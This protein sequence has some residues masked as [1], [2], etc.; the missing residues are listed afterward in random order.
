MRGDII[1]IR[2]KA[3]DVG[4]WKP[5]DMRE[6]V[7]N[8]FKEKED[9][10]THRTALQQRSFGEVGRSSLEV[11]MLEGLPLDKRAS[12]P[13]NRTDRKEV[14]RT[15]GVG[16]LVGNLARHCRIFFLMVSNLCMTL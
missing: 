1:Q 15:G 12:L 6:S 5:R 14:A 9:D 10:K 11:T 16:K 2:G 13:S 7:F 8:S 3:G 4:M